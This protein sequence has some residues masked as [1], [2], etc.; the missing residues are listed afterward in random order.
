MKQD[1]KI[2]TE[3]INLLFKRLPRTRYRLM[4]TNNHYDQ[5]YNFFF[6]SQRVYHRLKSV[7]LHTLTNYDLGE[8]EKLV[9]S[10]QQKLKFT[11]DFV[12][13]TGERWPQSQKIIQKK[14]IP[15]E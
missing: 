9:N 5:T 10:L 2:I 12:G 4:I 8:L 13:F 14:K 11:I 3:C 15:L 6:N 7:P 1:L